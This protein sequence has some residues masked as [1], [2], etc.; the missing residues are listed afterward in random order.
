M[1]LEIWMLLTLALLFVKHWYVDFVNQTM[2]EVHHKGIYLDWRGVKHSLKQGLATVAVFAFMSTSVEG[3]LFL[4]AVDFVLHYHIDWAKININ[5]KNNYTIEDPKFWM[6]LG[7]DQLAH[8]LTY[9]GLILV[10][11]YTI[12]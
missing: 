8:C 7:A 2:E 12:E 9:I 11:L 5:K 10:V 1:T 4:G 6:W 3:A